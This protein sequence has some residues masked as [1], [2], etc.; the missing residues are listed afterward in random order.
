VSP[1]LNQKTRFHSSDNKLHGQNIICFAKDWNEDPTSCNHVLNE[2]SKNNKVLWLN[3][4][5]TR[6]PNFSS[7]RDVRKIIRK[8]KD[9]LS[10][11]QQKSE[12]LWV[13]TPIV[14]PFPKSKFSTY[15]NL[16][17]LRLTFHVLIKKLKLS[18]FILWTFVPTSE[19]YCQ[20][21]GGDWIIYYCTDSFSNFT[22]VDTELISNM[23]RNQARKADVVFATSNLLV[24]ELREFNPNTHLASH[25]V[26]YEQFSR[27]LFEETEVPAELAS[28]P[29][30]VLGYYGLIEDWM[31]QNLLVYLAE[32]HPDWSI[33]L[34]GKSC[35]DTSILEAHPNIHLLGRKPHSLLPNYC[36]GFSVGLI[37]HHVNELTKHMNPIKLREYLCA[38]LPIVSTDLPEVHYYGEHCK[39]A[40]SYEEFERAIQ[41]ILHTDTPELRRKRSESMKEEGWGGK[42]EKIGNTIMSLKL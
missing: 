27:A 8:V 10:G 11:P 6:T 34:I 17:I 3:S 21:L 4:I 28:L 37:P 38:G 14:L 20:S 29:K 31:D 41:M 42:V 26:N 18:H 5:S 16:W 2:L 33:A 23:I 25:G 19:P 30:P 1:H 39:V 15:I 32:R 24:E 22:S 35:V 40:E 7:G 13:Y 9:F 36:K 12:N